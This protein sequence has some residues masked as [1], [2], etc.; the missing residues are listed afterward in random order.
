MSGQA[1]G[2]PLAEQLLEQLRDRRRHSGIPGAGQRVAEI[3]ELHRHSR[4]RLEI[5]VDHALAVHPQY[6]AISRPARQRVLDFERVLREA[7]VN[8]TVRVEKGS[9]Q[10]SRLG[11]RCT[12][13]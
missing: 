7:G 1:I 11:R 3:L 10:N 2:D 9:V 5:A 6:P 4:A 8:V 12:S 13:E